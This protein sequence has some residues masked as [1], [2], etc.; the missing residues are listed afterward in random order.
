MKITGAGSLAS[1]AF[2]GSAE[3]LPIIIYTSANSKDPAAF[4]LT[5]YLEDAGAATVMP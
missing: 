1:F 4:S 2:F 3:P 5:T